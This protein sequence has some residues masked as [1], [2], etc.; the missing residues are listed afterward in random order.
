MLVE[1]NQRNVILWDLI[2]EIQGRSSYQWQAPQ[3]V[4]RREQKIA[5]WIYPQRGLCELW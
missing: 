5:C 1:E 2:E 4:Q 3:E